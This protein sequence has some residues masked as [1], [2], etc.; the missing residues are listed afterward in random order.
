MLNYS[1]LLLCTERNWLFLCWLFQPKPVIEVKS[2][3]EEEAMDICDDNDS[4]CSDDSVEIQVDDD[5]DDDDLILEVPI[6]K[7]IKEL[8]E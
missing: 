4:T 2:D 1:L 7:T 5:D 3:D 8:S 6:R